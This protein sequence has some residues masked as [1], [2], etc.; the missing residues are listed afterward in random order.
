[1]L[2]AQEKAYIKKAKEL[3]KIVGFNSIESY[4]KLHKTVLTTFGNKNAS[5]WFISF[6]IDDNYN[7]VG[8]EIN[9]TY[10]RPEES[11]IKELESAIKKLNEKN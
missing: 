4:Y 8:F 5:M 6:P 9:S 11:K 7:I 10:F 1:M 3:A 2:D